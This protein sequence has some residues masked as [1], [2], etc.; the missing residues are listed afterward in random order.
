MMYLVNGMDYTG[1]GNGSYLRADGRALSLANPWGYWT[2]GNG[3]LILDGERS[4]Y[5]R[6]WGSSSGSIIVMR[7]YLWRSVRDD[8]EFSYACEYL[9]SRE[10]RWALYCNPRSIDG[11]YGASM[12]ILV[13]RFLPCC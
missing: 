13:I 2:R 10:N 4:A 5:Q 6:K 12:T 3:P 7:A 8:F 9:D 11:R 1:M